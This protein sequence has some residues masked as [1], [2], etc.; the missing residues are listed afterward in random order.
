MKENTKIV[1]AIDG[2]SSTGKSTVAKELAQ[3]LSYIYVDTGAMYRAVAL[4]ALQQKFITDDLNT[5]AL[6][7]ALPQIQIDFKK[8]PSGGL[9]TFLNQENVED[10]IRSLEVSNWVSDVAAI[11]QVRKKLVEQQQKIGCAKGCLLYTSD[12]ADD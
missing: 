2:H 3:H 5:D 7:A 10:Q 12:A 11:P 8:D 6:I 1:I 4:F 9:I